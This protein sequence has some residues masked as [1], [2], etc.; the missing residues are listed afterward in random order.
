MST[1]RQQMIRLLSEGECTIKDLSQ[2]LRISEREVY[3]HLPHV[4]KS[5]AAQNKTLGMPSFACQS[6]GFEFKNRKKFTR[7]SRC[8]Q[9]RSER[10][11]SPV[12]QI[13]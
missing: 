7:P 4:A 6:C 5:A 13:V 8:P 2:L 12:Y 11:G 9:C 10:I 3:Q 1:I